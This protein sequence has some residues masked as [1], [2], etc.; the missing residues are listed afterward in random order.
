MKRVTNTPHPK[1]IL[2][3]K[4]KGHSKSKEKKFNPNEYLNSLID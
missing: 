2:K 4:N 1:P 3:N